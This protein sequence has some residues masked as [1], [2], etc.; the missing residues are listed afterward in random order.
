MR[1]LAGNGV[2]VAGLDVNPSPHTSVV[3]SITDRDRVR[4][5]MRGADVIY[6][7]ATLHKPHVATHSKE[8]FVEVNVRGTLVLLEEAVAAGVPTFVFTSTTSVFGAA[9]RPAPGAPAAWVTEAVTPV[10]RNI[11]GVTKTAAEELCHLFHRTEGLACVVLR[12]SRFFL[13]YDDDPVTR[14]AHDDGNIK[15]NEFAHRRV[16]L[17]DV[18]SAHLLAGERAGAIG[19]G[20]YIISATTPFAREDVAEL[21]RDA[22]AVLRRRVPEHEAIYARLGWSMF[23]SID[24]VY[25]N[26]AARRDLGWEPAHE[27][28]SVLGRLDAGDALWSPLASAVGKKRYHETV[29]E[30]GPYPVEC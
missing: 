9:S 29:F 6:H 21:R 18:V 23:P 3:G 19:F 25:V 13:E 24:R 15:V 26:D 22:P 5:C 10:P 20:T 7:A 27:L 17:E 30:D 16:E 11:Y 12:T 8:D 4:E 2:E 14:A 1:T 28:A